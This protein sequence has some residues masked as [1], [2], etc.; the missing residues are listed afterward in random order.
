[1]TIPEIINLDRYPI[2]G[3]SAERST[4]LARLKSDLD[5]NQYCDLPDFFRPAALAQVISEANANRPLANDN[6]SRRNCYF[7]QTSDPDL[8][9]DHPRNIMQQTG[10]RMLGYGHVPEGSP[11]RTFYHWP[12]IRRMVAEIVGAERLY[13][14]EDPWQPANI[15]IYEPGDLSAWHFD[16]TNAFTMTLMMQAADAGGD[17]ELV[18]NTRSDTDQN[19]AHVQKVLLGQQDQDIVAV[20]RDPSALCIFRGCNS[21][22]R[23]SPVKGNTRRIMGVF[24]YEDKPGVKGDPVVN[25]TVYGV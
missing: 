15:L 18:P 21:M 8:P 6:N 12:E 16:S 14:N 23:V 5:Q 2:E 22:H 11:V 19:Y 17:F 20:G 24:V 1:M 13:E 9:A 25:A 3:D 7:E 4:L 10:N